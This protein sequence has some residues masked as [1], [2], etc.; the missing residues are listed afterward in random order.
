MK[1]EREIADKNEKRMES[2][3]SSL[4]TIVKFLKSVITTNAHQSN[5][6]SYSR[7]AV[8]LELS[9]LTKQRASL[10]EIV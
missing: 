5:D 1:M 6:G 7:T 3:Y 2:L 4:H 9:N 10:Q 8:I